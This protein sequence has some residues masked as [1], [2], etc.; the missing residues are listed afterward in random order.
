[1]KYLYIN[2]LVFRDGYLAGSAYYAK[3]LLR[4]LYSKKI[5]VQYKV[6]VFV[7][8]NDK[9]IS[10][11]D[12][13]KYDKFEVKLCGNF[14]SPVMRILYEQAVLPFLLGKS[15]VYFNPNPSMPFLFK[16]PGIKYVVT[17]HDLIP[18]FVKDKYSLSRGLYVRLLT[19]VSAKLSDKIVAVSE[20]TKNDLHKLLRVKEGKIIVIYNFIDMEY[21]ADVSYD[22]YFLTVCT[23]QPG[24]NIRR[25]IDAFSEFI[26]CVREEGFKLIIVGR[27]GYKSKEFLDYV[28]KKELMQKVIFTG[29]VTE[30]EKNS[31]YKKCLGLVYVSYYEGFGIPP[32]EAMF[33]NKSSVC[34]NVSSLPEVIGDTGY[35]VDPYSVDEIFNAMKSMYENPKKSISK[36]KN[37]LLRFKPSVVADKF[38][39]EVLA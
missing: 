33:Y 36:I 23:V 24:K 28:E 34:S 14:T 29:Y 21:V 31:Y 5:Y 11:F 30:N 32:L 20:S 22:K 39:K 9:V 6:Q 19:S 26:S 15:G 4:E 7:A 13:K 12:L 35:L 17:I 2:L 1:M 38:I 3:R 10:F 25:L 37:Q 8:N 27:L 18:F 16:K